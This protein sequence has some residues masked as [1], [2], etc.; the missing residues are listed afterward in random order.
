M[1]LSWQRL[2]KIFHIRYEEYLSNC[3]VVGT[4]SH[5]DGGQ[6]QH[7]KLS[8]LYVVWEV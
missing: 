6:D 1:Q 4:S 2:V 3:I 5:T 7:K 8:F